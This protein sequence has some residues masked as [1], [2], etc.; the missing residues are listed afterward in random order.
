[1]AITF[2]GSIAT[3]I[4]LGNDQTK[5]NL[6]VIQ[7]DYGSRHNVNIRRLLFQLDTINVLTTVMPQ[8]KASRMSVMS[9]GG[10]ELPKSAIIDTNET[11]DPYIS[12]FQTE[13]PG[14]NIVGTEG[15]PV[16]QQMGSRMH[17]GF[18]Q[19]IGDDNSQLPQLIEDQPFILHPGENLLIQVVGAT[20]PSNA[21]ITNNWWLQVMW[22]EDSLP[23][24]NISGTVTL[25]AS[26]VSGARVMVMEADD[27]VMTN[28]RLVE[29]KSTDAFGA[30]SSTIR[31]G[32]VGSAFVQYVS[33]GNYY[34]APGN[35]YLES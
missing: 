20:A 6:L 31:S 21:S 33:G 10:I 30:W 23:V 32:C 14:T 4:A 29:V 24:F 7:N 2:H 19:I 12:I 11:S 1:M 27:E 35:P 9:T 8:V 28:A 25:A 34:T 5:Q 17:T 15:Q 22:E 13:Y 18:S 3:F 26:P 16:W